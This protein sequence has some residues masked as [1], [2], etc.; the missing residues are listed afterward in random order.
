[1]NLTHALEISRY[2]DCLFMQWVL[3][4]HNVKQ[5]YSLVENIA[6]LIPYK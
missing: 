4:I 2:Q 5:L 6:L 3:R 1:M